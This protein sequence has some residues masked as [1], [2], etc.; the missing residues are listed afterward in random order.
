MKI[1]LLIV[2]GDNEH[3]CIQQDDGTC[4]MGCPNYCRSDGFTYSEAIILGLPYEECACAVNSL[5][6]SE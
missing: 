2:H 3:P 6:P 1:G 5:T 4:S